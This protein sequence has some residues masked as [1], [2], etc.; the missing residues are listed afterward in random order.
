MKP[1]ETSAR[2]SE[3]ESQYYAP[4]TTRAYVTAPVYISG[5]GPLNPQRSSVDIRSDLGGLHLPKTYFQMGP[6]A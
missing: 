4:P 6:V 3:E 5:S 1:Y 2:A